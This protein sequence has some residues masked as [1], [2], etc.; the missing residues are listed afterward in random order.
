MKCQNAL[1]Q[2]YFYSSTR[3]I[4]GLIFIKYDLRLLLQLPLCV[5]LQ[6]Y[7]EESHQSTPPQESTKHFSVLKAGEQSTCGFIT[8][9][10][11][12]M[13]LQ[14]HDIAYYFNFGGIPLG[15]KITYS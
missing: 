9:F 8:A 3:F 7:T 14:Q 1:K 6:R 4:V 13:N 12:H 11:P 2:I 10:A 5:K 15:L